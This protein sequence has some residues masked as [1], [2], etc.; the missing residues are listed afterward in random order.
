MPDLRHP[1]VR[2]QAR[3]RARRGGAPS[4]RGG[5]RGRATRA[6]RR[7]RAAA[8]PAGGTARPD[9][10]SRASDARTGAVQRAASAMVGFGGE[11]VGGGGARA[12]SGSARPIEYHV[13]TALPAGL[14]L[15][16]SRAGAAARAPI[17]RTALPPA[18]APPSGDDPRLGRAR[19]LSR[20]CAGRRGALGQLR[21]ERRPTR[22][23][24]D[25]LPHG[26]AR[27]DCHRLRLRRARADPLPGKSLSRVRSLAHVASAG[28]AA[29]VTKPAQN[30][31]PTCGPV[32]VH[33]QG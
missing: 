29:R 27:R 28:R 4:R 26:A 24:R 9:G 25:R 15:A 10:D 23:T 22:A 18:P 8:G 19:H 33:L 32:G 2:A 31:I 7:S 11:G 17:R 14:S 16:R 6:R 20:A 30:R 13:P 21:G 3:P 1:L 5:R 12:G